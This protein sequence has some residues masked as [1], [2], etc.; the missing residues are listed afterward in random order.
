MADGPKDPR[1]P[2][3]DIPPQGDAHRRGAARRPIAWPETGGMVEQQQA[4]NRTFR[5]N[6]EKLQEQ[7]AAQRAAQTDQRQPAQEPAAKDRGALRRET[8]EAAAKNISSEPA[9]TKRTLA[10]AVDRERGGQAAPKHETAQAPVKGLAPEREETAKRTLNFAMDRERGNYAALKKE[11]ANLPTR[12][13]DGDKDKA[14]GRRKLTFAMDKERGQDRDNDAGGKSEQTKAPGKT[15][16][17]AKDR[18]PDRG[19]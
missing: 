5:A 17:F 19:R 2:Q 6:S 4:A 13:G 7:T 10:F 1:P 8:A 12:E 11:T 9:P 3:K 15:L 14:P 16:S 18:G